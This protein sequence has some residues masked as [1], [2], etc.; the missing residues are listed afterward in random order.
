MRAKELGFT[1]SIVTNGSRITQEWLER[2]KY[3]LD[4][5]TLSI[6]TTDPDKMEELGRTTQAGPLT[7]SGYLTLIDMLKEHGIRL[8]INTVVARSNWNEDLTGFIVRAGPERWKILQVLP[9][10]GQNDGTVGGQLVTSEH[11]LAT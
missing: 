11:S 4:W 6:D 7:E 8:K 9:V 1:T 2:V 3:C 5:V 10:N